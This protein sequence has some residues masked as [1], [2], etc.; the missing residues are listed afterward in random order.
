[1]KGN[2]NA[3]GEMQSNFGLKHKDCNHCVQPGG[4]N[5]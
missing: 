2:G 5:F 4:G 1:V 3:R